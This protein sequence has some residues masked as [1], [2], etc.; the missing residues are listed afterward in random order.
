MLEEFLRQRC[1]QGGKQRVEPLYDS[2]R[3]WCRSKGVEPPNDTALGRAFT[4]AG[5]P[6]DRTRK[7]RLGVQLKPVYRV[8]AARLGAPGRTR[9]LLRSVEKFLAERCEDGGK[10]RTQHLWLAHGSDK[11]NYKE[12]EGALRRLGMRMRSGWTFGQRLRHELQGQ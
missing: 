8:V 4:G 7:Y 9:K 2:Y 3:E 10:E 5:Y 1:E 11:S 6:L 12:F